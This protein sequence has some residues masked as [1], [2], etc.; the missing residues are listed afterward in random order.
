M[1][2]NLT[3]NCG[4][5]LTRIKDRWVQAMP[6]HIRY[7]ICSDFKINKFLISYYGNICVVFFEA[8]LSIVEQ[9]G[10]TFQPCSLAD[11]SLGVGEGK[12]DI[13]TTGQHSFVLC[14]FSASYPLLPP[15]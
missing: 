10:T 12:D 9:N 8:Q 7:E 11:L 1:N 6:I 2:Q 14:F 3:A 4:S 15:I 13:G 5:S